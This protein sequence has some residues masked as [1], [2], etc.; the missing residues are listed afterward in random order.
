MDIFDFSSV[1]S[2]QLFGNDWSRNGC[3]YL[4][5]SEKIYQATVVTLSIAWV[6]LS[7][8]GKSFILARSK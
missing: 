4:S 6:I 2:V 3:I 8:G 1:Q 5:S 7:F